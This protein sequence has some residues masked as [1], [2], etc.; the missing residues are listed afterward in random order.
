MKKILLAVGLVVALGVGF[1]AWAYVTPTPDMRATAGEITQECEADPAASRTKYVGKTILVSGRLDRSAFS[2]GSPFVVLILVRESEA[3]ATVHASA[4]MNII[5]NLSPSQFLR[6]SG[7]IPGD[8]LKVVGRV[9][10]IGP[11]FVMGDCKLV[12]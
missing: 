5:C 6:S 12:N 7:L 4:R 10:D 1:V 11:H 2:A 3:P 8:H 9:A